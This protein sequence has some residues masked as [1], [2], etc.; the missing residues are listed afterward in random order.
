MLSI[1]DLAYVLAPGQA[2]VVADLPTAVEEALDSPA[3][4]P[5][6][7]QLVGPGSRVLILAD[8]VT[9]PTPQRRL[10]PLLLDYLNR[11]G[12]SERSIT[13]LAA[14]GS[15]RKMTRQE[16]SEHYGEIVLGNVALRN[17][18]YDDPGQ[19][20]HCGN[21]EDGTP[22]LV[23]RLLGEAD[24]VIG[25]SAILPHAQVGWGG[26][27]KIVLPGTAGEQTVARM[28]RIAALQPNYP[29]YAGV[30]ENPARALIDAAAAR[31]GLRFILNV[32]IDRSHRIV[33]VVS[34]EPL[35]AHGN[36][37]GLA[38][39]LYLRPV[40]GLADIVLV[41]ARPADLDYR[42]GLKPLTLG[43]MGLKEGGVLILW[44][45]FCDGISHCDD[46]LVHHGTRSFR[47]L[48]GMV[49]T[50]KLT[51]GLAIGALYQHARVKEKLQVFCVSEGLGEAHC[52]TLG[53]SWFPTLTQA[54]DR[55]VSRLGAGATVG[56]I[57][58][59]GE[60]VPVEDPGRVH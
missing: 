28:H 4:A 6:L 42:Q 56:I 41:D 52:E 25:V 30:Y 21:A 33:Q 38:S 16:L 5:A 31:A 2:P 57:E 60:V 20:R 59:G 26:G 23:N 51:N 54:Y 12:V 45:R 35:E 53:L 8:D 14:L 46:G 24:L 37:R 17:H 32:V 18:D 19:L 34:G 11:A 40:P 39:R 49:E 55:A 9:R 48:A 44:G 50:G 1:D 58:H 13:V 27:G 15:H 43:S 47:E 7:R 10:M 29:F 22:I 3:G 36:G